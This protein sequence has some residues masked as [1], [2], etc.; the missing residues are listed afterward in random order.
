MHKAPIPQAQRP[1][2]EHVAS[3]N[4][5][6]KYTFGLGTVSVINTSA[7]MHSPPDANPCTSRT[8]KNKTADNV[9]HSA[10]GGMLGTIKHEIDIKKVVAINTGTLP[11]VSPIYPQNNAARGRMQNDEQN[12]KAVSKCLIGES[13]GIK[14]ADKTTVK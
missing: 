9:P 11:I 8:D 2:S 12:M 13:G 1:P 14:I 5:L 4:A 7:A 3:T 10:Y 6:Q